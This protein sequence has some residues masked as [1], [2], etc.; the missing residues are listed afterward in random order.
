MRLKSQITQKNYTH[1][2]I[3]LMT[4]SKIVIDPA[5]DL[6]C[7]LQCWLLDK[8]GIAMKVMVAM[9]IMEMNV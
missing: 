8:W 9:V 3:G 2:L 5:D 7:H 4:H 1:I 6:H